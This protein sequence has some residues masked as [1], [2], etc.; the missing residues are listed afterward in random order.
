MHNFLD[1]KRK[2]AETF[3]GPYIITIVNENGPIKIITKYGKYDR[4]VNQNLFVNTNR[5]KLHQELNLKEKLNRGG[6]AVQSILG[7]LK[8]EG[9]NPGH[10][11]KIN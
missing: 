11:E 1:K 2:L 4:L 3:K 5:P 10:P 7:I 6:R 9:S 8:V